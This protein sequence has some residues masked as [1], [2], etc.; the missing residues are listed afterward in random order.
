MKEMPINEAT[1]EISDDV[2]DSDRL[3]SNG[4][5]SG[6][7][8]D[9][10]RIGM[11]FANKDELKEA[12]REYAIVQGRNVKLVKNDNRRIQAKCAGHTRSPFILFASKIDR[13]EQTFAIKTLSLEHECTRVDKL[14]YTNSRWLSNRFADKIRKNPEWDVGA[15]QSEVLEKYMNVSRHLIYR[16]KTLSKVIIE[17]SYVEQYARLW[18]CVEELKKANKGNTVIIKNKMK[19]DGPYTGQVLTAVGVDGNNGM[20]PVAYAV[21]E[22]ESKSSWIW[23]LELLITD[24]KIE[25]GKAWVFISDKQKGIIPAIETLLPTTEHKMCVR[26]IYSNFRTEHAGLALKNILWAAARATII[27]WYEAEME[28]MKQQDEEVWKWLIKR[29]AK[30]WSRSHFEPHSKCD[31]LLNN[32]CES[33]NSC[34]L[35]SRDKSILTCLERIRVYIMLRMANRR[36]A[37][38]VWRHPVGPRIFKITEKNKLGASQCIPRLAGESKYQV[39]HMYEGEYVVDLKAKTCSCRRWDLCGIPC[40]NAISCIFQKEA[41]VFDYAHDCYKKEAYLSSYEPMVHPIPSMD[42]WQ[43]TNWPP[44]KPPPYNKQPGRPKKSRNKEPAEVEVPAPVPPNPLPPFY[45]PPPTK[46]RRIYVKLRCSVCGQEG[47]NKT[48]HANQGAAQAQPNQPNPTRGRGRGRGRGTTTGRGRG[49]G[50]GQMPIGTG[51]GGGNVGNG[52]TQM[53]SSH[54]LSSS[55]PQMPSSQPL[56]YTGATSSSSQPPNIAEVASQPSKSPAKRFK[57]PAKRCG[58]EN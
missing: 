43:R 21:V 34:I 50:R 13:D 4:D 58:E 25:N 45:N 17:G 56:S 39:S 8:E 7:E 37:C 19:G 48:R 26:H 20:Y 54:P 18:D 51:Y 3:P 53:P 12:I 6:S 10:F 44:I 38:M 9:E 22:V 29:P 14:K 36:I 1:G 31:L 40:S 16:A 27:P 28:K 15:F 46:L 24:L 33:F 41:N 52:T 55:Q 23:F 49:N 42:Q 30:N 57:S 5:T 35:D 32:L 47:H 11:Q 2:E